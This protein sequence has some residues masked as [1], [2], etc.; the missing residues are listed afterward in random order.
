MTQKVNSRFPVLIHAC[1]SPGAFLQQTTA[2]LFMRDITDH[3][4]AARMHAMSTKQEKSQ[5]RD[6]QHVTG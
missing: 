6:S 5:L 3:L 4:R 1:A 2:R